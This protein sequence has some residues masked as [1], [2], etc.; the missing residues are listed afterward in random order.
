VTAQITIRFAPGEGAIGRIVTLIER[1]GF[2]LRALAMH[3][4]GDGASMTLDF[5]ARDPS[6]R[7]EVLDLQLKRIIGVTSVSIP[8]GS[9]Q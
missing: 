1:R 3:E 2:I 9:V 6:R 4:Q 5:V 7:F 8:T